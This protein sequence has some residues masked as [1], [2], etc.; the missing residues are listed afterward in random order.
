MFRQ[1]RENRPKGGLLTLV[2]NNIPAAEIQKSGQ[3]DLDTEYL[4]VKLVLA[5]TPVTVFNIF[6]P[7]NKQI[8]LHNI[9][10]EPQS[11]IITGGFN[12]HSPSWGYG[13]VNSK[14]EEV[15]NWITESW[16]ILINKP[17]DPDTFYFRIWRI[18]STPDQPLPLMTSKELLSEKCHHN[19]EAVT[20]GRWSSVLKTRH[21]PTETS[22]QQA[23]TIKKPTGC[24]Y[25]PYWTPELDNLHKA[26]D[27][28]RE[29]MESSPTS[30]N[31][32]A[33]SKA[34]AQYTRARTQATRNS[35]HE[36]T[37]S[38]NMEKD[39][40]GLWNLTR[41]LS[42]D[43]PSKSKT[44]IEANNELITEKRAANVFADL[45]QEQSTTHVA[46]ERIKEVRE[47]TENI[48]LSSY[49]EERDCSMTGPFSTKEVKDALKKMKTK[50]APGPDGITGEMLK[51]LGA[52]SRAV[53]LKIFN[54]SWIKG[55]APAVW[56]EAIVIPVSKKGKD[57]KNPR[58]YRPISLLSCVGKLLERMINRRLINHLESNNVLS[59]TQ[60]GYRKHRSTE[61][62]LAHLAQNI[63]DAFQ[64]KRKVLAVFFDLSNAFDKVWKEG[65]L[66]KL[67]R[68]GVRSKMCMWIQHFLF[69]RTARAKLDDIFS[70]KVCLREGVLQGGVLSPTLFLV[71]IDDILTTLSKKVSNTLNADDLAIWNASEHTTT[72]TYRIQEAI[73]DVSKW[74]IGLGPRDKY[75]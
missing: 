57:R 20:T 5:G 47:E 2:R 23:G 7:P 6:S 37:A 61:D 59:P 27:Q 3:A 35:W 16:L 51:H 15:E 53:L 9:K 62:Q 60:T 46:R 26:L 49:G 74:T 71:Y 33:H 73:S 34:K 70:K 14:G 4:G 38:L 66:V 75:Q 65:L 58:S 41:A 69:A 42:N 50:K 1:D 13:Q 21:S 25:Q 67:L 52:C 63:E 31:V 68:T 55:V 44:V 32:E 64:E 48:I 17:D 30:A 45:Y 12:S 8:Q 36:K 24:D 28:A 29:K 39:M 11:W 72:A 40:T 18:T 56:K 10:I 22:Y 43:Y 19:L 54:H